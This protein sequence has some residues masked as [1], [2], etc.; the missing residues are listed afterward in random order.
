M[1]LGELYRNVV[2][3]GMEGDPRPRNVV[4]E[5]LRQAKKFYQGLKGAKKTFFDKEK[6]TNPYADTRILYGE[7]DERIKTIMVGIDM[8]AEELLLC[9]RLRQDG[10]PIDLV[11]AHHPQGSALARLSQ[12]MSIQ[13]DLLH[14]MGIPLEV[15]RELMDERIKEIERA[16]TS[17]NFARYVDA[18]R[19]LHIPFM[20]CHTVADNLVTSFL[21]GLINKS[22]PK[23]LKDI[24]EILEKIPE[25]KEACS[26]DAGPSIVIGKPDDAAGKVFIDMTG[27]TEGSK[28]A[29]SRLSQAGVKTM[30]S[31]H[32]SEEHIKAAKKEYINFILAGHISSDNIGIN[33]L[34]D[35]LRRIENFEVIPCSGFVRI[36]R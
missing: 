1:R 12:V 32:L 25:Y 5:D 34:L 20:C 16:F 4:L 26:A 14:K 3:I 35:K 13:S 29:F 18:A 31:M 30:V 2:K 28:R 8:G 15:A 9:D 33:L 24:V 17:R 19:L 10:T 6:L 21:Q 23:R 11:M 27:G 22:K 7:R 36:K